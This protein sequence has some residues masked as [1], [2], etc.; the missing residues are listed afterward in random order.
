M[1]GAIGHNLRN[2]TN[3]SG[4]DAR[5][6]FW[7]YVLAIAILRFVA[8]LAVSI[9]MMIG[10]FSGAFSAAQNGVSPDAMRQHMMGSVGAY[11]PMM[12]WTGLAIGVLSAVLLA[13]SFVRRLHDSDL[14]GWWA[15]LPLGLYAVVLARMPGQIARAMEVMNSMAATPGFRPDPTAMMREQG[16]LAFLVYVPVLLIIFAGVRGSTSGPNRFGDEPG[17]F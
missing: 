11:L 15:L 10:M 1:F 13:A 2:L 12:L 4:R 9:P 17:E 3:F 16:G 5:Q 6:T 8:G 14:S 7:F